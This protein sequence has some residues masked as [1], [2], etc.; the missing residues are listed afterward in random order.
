[1]SDGVV[2]YVACAHAEDLN[3]D[4]ASAPVVEV[5]V[6]DGVTVAVAVDNTLADEETPAAPS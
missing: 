2:E 1:L 3:D 5:E 6:A 4:D